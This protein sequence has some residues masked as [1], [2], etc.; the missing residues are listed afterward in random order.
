M[1]G[2]VFSGSKSS[3]SFRKEGPGPEGHKPSPPALLSAFSSH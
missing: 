1:L 3:L 2:V